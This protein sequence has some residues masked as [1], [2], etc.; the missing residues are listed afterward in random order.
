MWGIFVDSDF[1]SISV[2]RLMLNSKDNW[3]WIVVHLK[4]GWLKKQLSR[5]GKFGLSER[6]WF[7]EG[8]V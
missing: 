3:D 8:R 5:C 2:D 1:S 7:L 6:K 4:P